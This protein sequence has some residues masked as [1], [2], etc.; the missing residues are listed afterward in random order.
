MAKIYANGIYCIADAAAEDCQS[1]SGAYDNAANNA[2][3]GN[4]GGTV[5]R[6]Y[7]RM[8]LDIPPGAQILEAKLRFFVDLSGGTLPSSEI[9]LLNTANQGQFTANPWS[10]SY[11][12][13]GDGGPISWTDLNASAVDKWCE[14]PDLKNMIQFFVNQGTGNYQ[15]GNYIGLCVA[16]DNATTNNYRSV[17]QSQYAVANAW[18]ILLVSY[19]HSSKCVEFSEVVASADDTYSVDDA[20]D[21]VTST[22]LIFGMNDAKNTDD[23]ETYMRFKM[24]YLPKSATLVSAYVGVIAVTQLGTAFNAL[25]GVTG[26]E[27]SYGA[28]EN[29]AFTSSVTWALDSTQWNAGGGW[30]SPTL[31]TPIGF[32]IAEADYDPNGSG[33]N[34]YIGMSIKQSDAGQDEYRTIGA[35]DYNP[36]VAGAMVLAVAWTPATVR[37]HGPAVAL[38]E[39]AMMF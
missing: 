36:G 7:C 23:N 1:A 9:R 11:V 16:S 24:K 29:R 15:S 26:T 33:N 13:S 27:G 6:F 34:P 3:I 19:R 8:A 32:R 39:S 25:I 5:S 4:Y 18:V 22:S 31:T 10:D 28:N 2:H 17:I 38:S 21:H 37:R 35:Y 20:E 30:F 12:S 14:S